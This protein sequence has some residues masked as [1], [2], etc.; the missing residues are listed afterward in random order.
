MFDNRLPWWDCGKTETFFDTVGSSAKWHNPHE[1]LA[2]YTDYACGTFGFK[3]K[4]PITNDCYISFLT[5]KIS[6]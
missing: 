4:A 2:L 6:N 3:S 1:Y 5:L